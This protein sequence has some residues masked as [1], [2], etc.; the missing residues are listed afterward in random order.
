MQR[1]AVV[2]L[3][4]LLSSASNFVLVALVAHFSAPRTFGLF[5]IAFACYVLW[6]GLN[7]AVSLEIGLL[8]GD[9][10]WQE[11]THR[12]QVRM[13]SAIALVGVVVMGIA[14]LVASGPLSGFFLLLSAS[15]PFLIL[16]DLVRYQGFSALGGALTRALLCDL[17]W[18]LAFALSVIV[19][20][21]MLALSGHLVF[22]LWLASGCFAGIVFTKW[23]PLVAS[24]REAA[25]RMLRSHR[26]LVVG[27]L[28]EFM[29]S[30]GA[31]QG[32][33]IG[34]AVLAS[35]STA[36]AWRIAL[37][38]FGP[39][40]VL[41]AAA[42]ITG[43]SSRPRGESTPSFRRY[44]GAAAPLVFLSLVWTVLAL[45]PLRSFWRAVFGPTWSDVT[46]MLPA[47][48]LAFGLGAFVTVARS[49]VRAQARPR[50]GFLGLA[51]FVLAA[52]GTTI[53]GAAA[54]GSPAAISYCF[55]GGTA[56]SLIVWWAVLFGPASELK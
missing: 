55:L 8:Q 22:L 32:T 23:L 43:I 50:A 25:P 36:G 41:N 19:A 54:A 35:P 56:L 34:I 7:R 4:Q 44:V 45:G 9:S 53:V 15:L 21:P 40:T 38:L 14:G 10:Q 27:Y 13:S 24:V 6:I 46:V 31:G 26:P 39:L 42:F 20:A 28:G 33:V 47:I 12:H 29:A 17:F 1:V 2:T 52:Y 51:A 3:D 18:L 11:D 49:I 48:G 30:S 37:T 16:Q 5:A